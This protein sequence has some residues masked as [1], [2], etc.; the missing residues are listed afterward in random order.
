MTSRTAL[1]APVAL[2]LVLAAWT[3]PPSPSA[4]RAP[5]PAAPWPAP[6]PAG[7]GPAARE[8]H[9]WTATPDGATAYLFGGRTAAGGALDDLWAYDL[10]AH[11]WRQG[12]GP[13]PAAR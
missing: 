3:P 2:I 6:A 5:P 7:A 8:D 10:S 12:G 11:T 4:S 13:R 1:S 9:T